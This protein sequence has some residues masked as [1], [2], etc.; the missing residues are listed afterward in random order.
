MID[1]GQ[2]DASMKARIWLMMPVVA[3]PAARALDAAP[4]RACLFDQDQTG[5]ERLVV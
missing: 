3:T 1:G 5:R 4:A 2:I